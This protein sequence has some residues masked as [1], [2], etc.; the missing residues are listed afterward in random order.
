MTTLLGADHFFER[1][2]DSPAAWLFSAWELKSGAGRVDWLA[3]PLTPNQDLRHLFPIYRL[4]MGLSFENLFKGILIAQ[5]TAAT[6]GGKLKTVFKNHDLNKLANKVEIS[7]LVF[8]SQ[9]RKLLG[10]LFLFVEWQGRY[11][12]PTTSS[13]YRNTGCYVLNDLAEHE[14]EHEF[15]TRLY[16]HLA[17]IGWHKDDQGNRYKLNHDQGCVSIGKR[18]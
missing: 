14:L 5:G 12:I 15:W 13:G 8:S 2:G 10:D 9:E 7:P 11:P 1:S 17:T 3:D 18:M 6:Q 16:Q 4:L